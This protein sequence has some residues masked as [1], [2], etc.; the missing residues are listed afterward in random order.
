MPLVEVWECTRTGKFFRSKVRYQEHLRKLARANLLKRAQTKSKFN[1][2]AKFVEMRNLMS[3]EEITDWINTH[4]NLFVLNYYYQ[5]GIF[6]EAYDYDNWKLF[7]VRFDLRGGLSPQSCT[8]SAPFGKETNWGCKPDKPT[9]YPGWRGSIE[10]EYE[11][12][13]GYR[14]FSDCFRG[15]GINTGTGGSASKKS[16]YDVILFADDWHGLASRETFKILQ[17]PHKPQKIYR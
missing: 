13:D 9:Y 15:T 8:H 1:L 10:I 11:S 7:T 5:S 3:I 4:N 2:A 12:N 14:L 16:R 17:K 6:T